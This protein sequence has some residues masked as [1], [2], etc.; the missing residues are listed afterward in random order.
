MR[1]YKAIMEKDLKKFKN[2]YAGFLDGA[3]L[4]ARI[5][6]WVGVIF[7]IYGYSRE[8]GGLIIVGVAS[9]IPAII[10]WIFFGVAGDNVKSLIDKVKKVSNKIKNKIKN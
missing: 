3:A 8:D 7:C 10:L 6:L 2:K 5:F 1:D 9:I 4:G